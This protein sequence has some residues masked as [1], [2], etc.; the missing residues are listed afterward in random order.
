M[1]TCTHAHILAHIHTH[2]HIL[3]SRT[4]VEEQWACNVLG[5]HWMVTGTNSEPYLTPKPETL[6]V[7]DTIG[8]STL[9]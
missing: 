9:R 8:W 6:N 3:H 5:Y 4:G 1:H 7:L 2:I